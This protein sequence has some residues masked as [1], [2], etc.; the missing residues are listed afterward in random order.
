MAI[1]AFSNAITPTTGLEQTPGMTGDQ[2]RTQGEAFTQLLT[3]PPAPSLD[4]A[5]R[6]SMLQAGG[7]S[8]LGENISGSLRKF[9]Q[10]ID[11]METMGAHKPR[12][13]RA[14]QEPAPGSTQPSVLPGP[15]ERN[16]GTARRAK[17]GEDHINEAM[18]MAQDALGH[19]AQLYKVMM[20]FT[21]VHSSAESLNKSL[22]TLL[23]QGGG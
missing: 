11:R 8:G 19:Q 4:V 17:A 6:T 13:A 5:L 10:T 15:A 20:D 16:P 14:G 3:Q 2:G 7:Q 12:G 23:T 21:L 9:G 1:E 22:K 18:E